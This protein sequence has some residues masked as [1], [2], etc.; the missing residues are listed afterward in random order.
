VNANL[1]AADEFTLDP[2]VHGK[3]LTAGFTT[4][5]QL[6][7][8][9]GIPG[10]AYAFK[11]EGKGKAEWT[12]KESAYILITHTNPASEKSMLK[13]AL[14]SAKKEIEKVE[15]ARKDWEAKRKKAE[16][17]K[18]KAEQEKKKAE[19]KKKEGGEGGKAP[20]AAG[21]EPEKKPPEKAKEEKKEETFKP[22]PINPV[23]QPLVDLIQKKEDT[24]A[25]VRLGR[26][27]D[28]LHFNE[29]VKNYE[30][31][32]WIFQLGGGRS[33][34]FRFGGGS[35]GG[36][37]HLALDGFAKEK[38]K[39]ILRSTITFKPM[40][41]NRMN[42]PATFAGAG[43]EVSLVP[44]SDTVSGHAAFLV[45]MAALIKGGMDR[46]VALRAI[47]LHPARILGLGDRVGSLEKGKDAN[48]LFL[49]NDPFNTMTRVEKVMIQG[50][51]AAEGRAIQ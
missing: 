20:G 37:F 35:S 9:S 11:P 5:G 2:K 1:K 50:K 51:I 15:K 17:D 8:G 46:G 23:Y 24:R 30:D 42:L 41:R 31:L 39:V 21:D 49:T 40:T 26:A 29:A 34:G 28:R 44:G 38:A 36:D 7:Q 14:G 3:L 18:K 47:T 32:A 27:S 13:K 33:S 12:L 10:Q 48:L 25:V 19:E 45:E 43:C 16:E 6:P 4:L 22:P